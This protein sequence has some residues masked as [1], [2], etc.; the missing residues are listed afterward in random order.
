MSLIADTSGILVLLERK[1][2]L[3]APAKAALT[4]NLLVPA[5]IL[6]ELD[7]LGAAR[8]GR[9]KMQKFF[10]GLAG[11]EGTYTPLLE[12]DLPRTLEVMKQYQDAEVGF[13]DASI[14]ALA[15]RYKVR[16]VL[17]LDRRHFALFKPK[18]LGYLEILP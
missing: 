10:E 1:H 18:G 8:L 5:T 11:G 15:E 7:Y 13:V 14:V 2:P 6:P 9:D 4:G 17:T 12:E 16:R 3:H